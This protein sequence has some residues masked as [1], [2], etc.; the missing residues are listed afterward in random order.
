MADLMSAYDWS[1]TPLGDPSGWSQSL[2]TV[3]SILLTSQHPIFLWWGREL[4]QFYND[5]YRPILGT[6]K[7][8]QAMGQRGR[9]C[10]QEI[11]D[12]IEPTIEA[13][14]QRGE[15]TRI[16]DGLLILERNGYLE[17]C[18]FNYAYSPVRDETGA[19][20][21]VFCVCDETTKRVVGERQLK[22]LRELA[23][24]PMETQIVAAACQLSMSAIA[25]NPADL[26][27][28]LLYL[29]DDLG[30]G[31]RLMGTAGI[32]PGTIA[33][34][35]RIELATHPW[36]LSKVR[37]QGQ[38][39]YIIDLAERFDSL[40]QSIWQEPPQ[41]AIVVPLNRAGQQQLSGFLILAVSPRRAFDDEYRG[42]FEVVASQVEIAIANARDRERERQRADALA[43]LD[44]AK[45]EF[46]SN[47]SHEFRTPLTLMLSPL[48]ET[49]AN[50]DGQIPPPAR[51][52]LQLVQRNG[53]RL[54]KLVNNLLD[55]S[56]L[57]AGRERVV[58]ELLDL[59]TYTAELASTFRSTIE[60]AGLSLVVECPPLPEPVWIDR[61]MWEKIILNLLSNAFKFTLVGTISVRLEWDG[62]RVQLSVA[63]TGVGIPTSELPRLF[64]RFHRV[65]NSQG[66]SFE[67]SG[68]GLSLVR[69]L[70]K[71]QGGTIEVTSTLGQGSC[72]AISMPTGT[73]RRGSEPLVTPTTAL[74]LTARSYVE[75]ARRWLPITEA[76]LT[77]T[78][79]IEDRLDLAPP[80]TEI[81]PD[82]A[83]ILLVD[84]NAD[85]R[86]YIR[87]LLSGA[88]AVT[89]VADG[90][91]ALAAIENQLPD[92]V[93]TDVMMPRMDGFELLRS[94]R[95]NP[96]AKDI[97]IV[98]LSARTGEESRIEGLDAGADDYLIKPFSARE[99][100][101]RVEAT[102]KLARQRQAAT[103]RE[104]TILARITDAFVSLDRD[105]RF[106]Y[107]NEA[108]QRLSQTPLA[109]LIGKTIW[110]VFPI[111]V[112]SEFELACRRSIATQ[113]AIELEQYYT[114][115]DLW[116]E[117]HV[118]PSPTGLSIFVRDISDR[119]R[120]EAT[121]RQREQR[122]REM[123]DN[124]PM[125]VW[126]TDP[127]GFCTYL[128]RS[129]Y[130]FSGQTEAT[131]LGFGWLEATH[132]ADREAAKDIFVNANERQVAFQI[133]YRLQRKDGL[134][135]TCIDAA[136]PWFDADGKF[137]GYIGSVIDI[138]ERK[139]LEATLAARASELTNLNTLLAHS[140]T[141]LQERN[142]ELDS[143]VHIVSHDLKAPLRAIANLSE[144][145]EEDLAAS[146]SPDIAEQMTLLR[147]R[148]YRME[149][150]I[151]GLLDYSRAGRTDT[152]R[153]RVNIAE[154]LA[155]TIDSI[156]PP[157]TFKITIDPM[158]TIHAQRLLLARVFANLIGNA[159]KHHDRADGSVRISSRDLGDC[160]EF[161]IAD[162]GCGIAPEDRHR[163]FIIFQSANPQKHPDSSGIGLSIV[164]KIVEAESGTIR[165]ESELDLGTTFYFT[166]PKS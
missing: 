153:E 154:L 38:P 10:W 50:L 108:A 52:Q 121:L 42:F 141:L 36:Q 77:L 131:G 117:L 54:L 149:A 63:D 21:G 16:Q 67:G 128:S 127:T 19:V 135:R 166:W 68:I 40:P 91:E 74:P 49:I 134:Y 87:R 139:Q 28:A 41:S 8:P 129:W 145:I 30:D 59:A 160:Y 46:F 152:Q 31:A 107:A 62:E 120:I 17:E 109:A 6:T 151:V 144:W 4:I 24:Q 159:I 12:V 140:A 57:E 51:A 155:E 27:F 7:H 104:R 56:R 76:G 86:D 23:A 96:I 164:K 55:F 89:T 162:D 132:P 84:D 53:Q 22:T 37:Q 97:P 114:P 47:V 98:L 9:E 5:A 125:M 157:P 156:A 88:Y 111:K 161:A 122:F 1:Q 112:G 163:I 18:Y 78:E 44:R 71:L 82:R 45:T 39:A 115:L 138:D 66:R 123:A 105:L 2:K 113:V 3:L 15:S 73:A 101:A 61:Q 124:A 43:A 48:A 11:W 29:I 143:F 79:S 94:L 64:D 34:P 83:R 165:V 118:Y 70:V 146:L 33:S 106:T 69:E 133:E 72:F 142:R 126:V 32:A 92:L 158:P 80:A 25:N 26:P 102:L 85:M 65:E 13:V 99:L 14:T 58:Y 35:D 20:G 103:A 75:E 95:S 60:Q 150:T 93:L 136:R 100:L 116:V 110:E 119:K 148:V 81:P 90:V 147:R 130:E 137:K